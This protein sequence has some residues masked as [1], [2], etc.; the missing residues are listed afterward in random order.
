MFCTFFSVM[1]ACFFSMKA[2]ET[3]NADSPKK[4]I[5]EQDAPSD[6]ATYS[7]NFSIQS[8]GSALNRVQRISSR[9]SFCERNALLIHARY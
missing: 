6:T 1:H 4:A 7:D 5:A 3:H 2:G 9:Y 8:N